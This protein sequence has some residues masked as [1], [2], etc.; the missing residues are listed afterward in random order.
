MGSRLFGA[1]KG[2]PREN[3]VNTKEGVGFYLLYN[4]GSKVGVS[5]KIKGVSRACFPL[6]SSRVA[7]TGF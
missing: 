4:S 5:D 6:I 3:T 1:L 2:D 7:G